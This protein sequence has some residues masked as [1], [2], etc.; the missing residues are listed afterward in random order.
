MGKGQTI[1]VVSIAGVA[2]GLG[3]LGCWWYLQADMGETELAKAQWRTDNQ[4]L[5]QENVLLQEN[6]A[7]LNQSVTTLAKRRMA[8]KPASQETHVAVLQGRIAALEGAQTTLEAGMLGTEMAKV[9]L[10]ADNQQ[11]RQESALL[12]ANALALKRRIATLESTQTTLENKIDSMRKQLAVSLA[13][14]DTRRVV[15]ETHRRVTSLPQKALTPAAVGSQGH[16]MLRALAN[17]E[18][19]QLLV[20]FLVAYEHQ[21]PGW[22]SAPGIQ[23][24]GGQQG[25]FALFQYHSWSTL[26]TKLRRMERAGLVK[27]RAAADPR[28]GREFAI[29][30]GAPLTTLQTLASRD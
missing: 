8:P 26:D 7:R 13:T 17:D 22:F 11:L 25:P 24:L 19:V 18:L 20:Q 10:H 2:L 5:R 1:R 28:V 9:Q 30:H 15:P 29:S 14:G 4:Q 21:A 6:V 23:S 27:G 12:Q 3:I 16:D